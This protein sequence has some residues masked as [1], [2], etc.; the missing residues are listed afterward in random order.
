MSNTTESTGTNGAALPA[1]PERVF[2]PLAPVGNAARMKHMLASMQAQI[3]EILPKHVRAER[4]IKSALVAVNRQPK[5]LECTQSSIMKAIM[6]ASELGLDPSG[7]TLG[8]GYLVPFNNKV[9]GAD[10][11]ETWVSQATFI[12]GYRGLCDLARRGGEVRMIESHVVFQG[13]EFEYEMGTSRKLRHVRRDENEEDKDITHGYSI[14]WLGENEYQ[15]EVMTRRQIEKI[16]ARSKAKDKGPW[17][18]DFSEMCRKTVIRRL[19]KYLPISSERLAKAID[20]G[21]HNEYGAQLAG[22]IIEGVAAEAPQRPRLAGDALAGRIVDAD[23]GDQQRQLEG[24][25][26]GDADSDSGGENVDQS[27]DGHSANSAGNGGGDTSQGGMAKD[28][29]ATSKEPNYADWGEFC[30]TC[31]SA[32]IEVGMSEPELEKFRKEA[33]VAAGKVGKGDQTP[34]HWRKKFLQSIRDWTRPA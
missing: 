30:E 3:A 9:K 17:V 24:A 20:I 14:A 18:T 26:P 1:K 4:I 11:R 34:V 2:D 12:P 15:F 10:G 27:G 6:E 29:K 7:G 16:R 19:I 8:Q 21:D 13:D 33:L 32:A 5:L 31:N 28:S 25:W 22:S 23:T